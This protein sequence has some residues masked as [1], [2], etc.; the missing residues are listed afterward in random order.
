MTGDRAVAAEAL[1]DQDTGGSQHAKGRISAA[2]RLATLVERAQLF[3]SADGRAYGTLDLGQHAETWPV[4]SK[5]F[6]GWLGSAYYDVI[7][8]PA[9]GQAMAEALA[10][11]EARA[12]AGVRLSVPVRVAEA[13]GRIYLDL[14]DDRWRMV[15]VDARGWRVLDRGP[16]RFRRAAGMLALPEPVRGGTV[17]DLR[18]LVNVEDDRAWRLI[19][20]WLLMALSPQGPYPVLVL[21]GEH[22]SAKTWMANRLR[23]LVDPNEAPN[24][25]EPREPRDLMIAARNGWV[26]AF[27]N[28]STLHP[29]FSDGLCRLATGSGFATRELYSD[30]DEVIFAAVRPVILNG[31]GE[32]VT[33]P[34]LL[35]RS[36][37]LTLPMIGDDRRRDER[38]LLRAFEAVRPRVLGALLN[39]VSAALLNRDAVRLTQSPRQADFARWVTAG[40]AGLG[41]PAGAFMGAYQENRADAHELALEASPIAA[42]LRSLIEDGPWEGTASELLDAIAARSNENVRRGREWP[43]SPRALSSAVRRIAPNLRGLGIEVEFRRG[44]DASRRRFLRIRQRGC[45][46]VRTVQMV[47]GTS[48]AMDGSDARLSGPAA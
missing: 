30:D 6:R 32:V 28:I 35:D 41:W 42:G 24:R 36:V 20:G 38:D 9:P 21:G 12:L 3:H 40:E 47:P 8:K 29:W 31:I 1:S 39:A 33:R 25:A 37:L 46:S 2:E 45:A 18:A 19:V 43:S 27:D 26:L 5:R 7:R 23:D 14:G 48:D 15:E 10:L 44:S 17:D 11:A 16:V 13:D 4:R 22:G 34:D